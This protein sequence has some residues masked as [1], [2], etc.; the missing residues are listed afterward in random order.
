[1]F[2]LANGYAVGQSLHANKELTTSNSLETGSR[3]PDI[4]QIIRGISHQNSQLYPDNSKS[5]IRIKMYFSVF[6]RNDEYHQDNI[7]HL[8]GYSNIKSTIFTLLITHK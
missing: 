6:P 5:K 1:V 7:Q 3:T 4:L 2:A 8:I